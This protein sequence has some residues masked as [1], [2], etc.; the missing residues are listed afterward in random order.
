MHMRRIL[1]LSCFLLFVHPA[2]S[3]TTPPA[4]PLQDRY[5]EV[6]EFA[7]GGSEHA[8]SHAIVV[9]PRGYHDEATDATNRRS[10]RR[11]PVVY[12]LHGYSGNYMNWYDHSMQVNRPLWKLASRYGVILVLP[13]GKF[14]SWYLDASPELA[15]SAD[16]QW[17]AAIT[18]YL[19]PQIDRRYRTRAQAR[20]RGI[21]GLS[22]GGHGALYLAARHPELFSACSS[23]SGVM[24]LTTALHKYDLAKRRGRS[25]S[26]EIDGLKAA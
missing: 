16:W 13:D 24:D 15:D 1:I 7:C 14:S 9:L 17:E 21:C 11:W 18:R 23:M 10:S 8:V 25:K 22:M 6:I 26:S 20:S 4:N 3:Q 19:I 5:S 2:R 12:V